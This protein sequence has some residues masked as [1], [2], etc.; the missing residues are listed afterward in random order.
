LCV[1]LV[2]YQ[3]SGLRYFEDGLEIK[4]IKK[5]ISRQLATPETRDGDRKR[6]KMRFSD[7]TVYILRMKDNSNTV[8]VVIQT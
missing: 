5:H 4:F 2:I 6:I 1:T 3:E 8:S 7:P